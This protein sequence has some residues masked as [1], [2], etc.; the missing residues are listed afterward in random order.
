MQLTVEQAD[1]LYPKR[2]EKIFFLNHSL[3][4][5]DCLARMLTSVKPLTS[6]IAVLIDGRSQD[7]TEEIAKSFGAYTEK[8]KWRHSFSHAKN[9]CIHAAMEKLGLV[10]GDWVMF[11]GADFELQPHTIPEIRE[12]VKDPT[13]FFAQFW[14]PEYHPNPNEKVV[15]RKR[16]LLWRHH[17]LIYWEKSAHEEAVYSAYRLTGRG[18][19]FGEIEWKDFPVLG[20]S[21]GMLHYGFHEDGGE[22]GPEFWRKKM[23]YLVLFQMDSVRYRYNLP[24][25]EQGSLD[26]LSYIFGTPQTDINKS[27]MELVER[28]SRGE[29]P[30]NLEHKWDR[31]QDIDYSP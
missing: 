8:F 4:E 2:S 18:L 17:P 27:I 6:D 15:T 20:G 28:F 7:K 26:A 31:I 19:P 9:L 14:V 29:I 23:Y 30:K 16:K 10:Y 25:T 12:F 24:E 5:E 21:R 3:N 11:M 1:M 13:H 22:N